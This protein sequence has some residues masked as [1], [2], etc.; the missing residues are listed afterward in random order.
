[1]SFAQWKQSYRKDRICR[2]KR[3][4]FYWFDQ[5]H[6]RVEPS[7]V[8]DQTWICTASKA[9]LFLKQW[10]LNMRVRGLSTPYCQPVYSL[11]TPVAI[12]HETYFAIYGNLCRIEDLYVRLMQY[13]S[14]NYTIQ[15]GTIFVW[16]KPLWRE[17]RASR[18]IDRFLWN[19]CHPS[20]RLP[21]RPRSKS[22]SPR[23]A[24]TLCT[25]SELK[26]WYT[27]AFHQQVIQYFLK[28]Q[29]TGIATP[30]LVLIFGLPGSGKN[31]V[32]EKKREKGHVQIN[33]DDIRALLP[34]YWKGLT[35]VN[36]DVPD[37][38][39]FLSQECQSIAMSI[40][41]QALRQRM[42]M[43][44]NG[45]GKNIDKYERLLNRAKR[46][47]YITELR[48]IWVPLDVARRRVRQ[49]SQDIGRTVPDEVIRK[50]SRNIPRVFRHL[51]LEAD[52]A[53]IFENQ[54]RSPTMIWDKTQGWSCT[55]TRRKSISI[56]GHWTCA[57]SE[58]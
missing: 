3:E 33:V 2:S 26:T 41:D 35:S 44:W 50:A 28:D 52:H 25:P 40:F 27:K 10:T 14:S 20:L 5:H 43:V 21:R 42:N 38:I 6:V 30:R 32:L 39:A 58:D 1:M 7:A 13:P 56:D 53:R 23:L 15:R 55:P 18:T 19:C 29:P 36:L 12:V 49:R 9:G 17:E 48:Y 34:K 47:G 46:Q 4:L 8:Q 37:W 51:T 31:W 57:E 22:M 11:N 24:K 54:E 16:V 45:T